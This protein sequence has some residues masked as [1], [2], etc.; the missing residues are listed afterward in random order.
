M[1][2]VMPEMKKVCIPL[3]ILFSI[4]TFG[5]SASAEEAT[6]TQ[7]MFGSEANKKIVA[8]PEKV[9]ISRIKLDETAKF[10]ATSSLGKSLEFQNYKES[11]KSE[12]DASMVAGVIKALLDPKMKE[13]L[14]GAK[15]C[16]LQFGVR[17]DYISNG[18][19]ITAN[20][21]FSC[22]TI[23]FSEKGK[24]IGGGPFDSVSKAMKS[25]VKKL[26]PKDKVI[27]KL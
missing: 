26:F 19:T 15:G 22:S 25:E 21:C 16:L 10:T 3:T 13:P 24:C 7:K 2:D 20:L 23:A 18:R 6:Y 1:L 12:V 14:S 17:I 27:Q 4:L 5:Q 9:F 11:S 8:K